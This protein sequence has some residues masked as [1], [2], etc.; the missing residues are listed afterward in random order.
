R[1]VARERSR[2]SCRAVALDVRRQRPDGEDRVRQGAR[3]SDHAGY[4]RRPGGTPRSTHRPALEDR[5]R[6]RT[7]AVFRSGLGRR[8]DLPRR[9]RAGA[10]SRG[11]ELSTLRL[12]LMVALVDTEGLEAYPAPQRGIDCPNALLQLEVD[13]LQP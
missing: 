5:D 11:T 4:A 13:Q 1:L 7:V 8:S 3:R 12:S 2:R 6:P 10:P 9:R